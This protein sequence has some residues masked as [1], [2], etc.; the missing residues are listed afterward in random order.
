VSKILPLFNVPPQNKEI[1]ARNV[2]PAGIPKWRK[3]P[4]QS[5]NNEHSSY[6]MATVIFLLGAAILGWLLP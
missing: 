3:F 5:T 6:I 1:L 2:V 4:I